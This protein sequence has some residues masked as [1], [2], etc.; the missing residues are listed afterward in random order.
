MNWIYIGAGIVL[1][2]IL[3]ALIARKQPGCTLM[4]LGGGIHMMAVASL[5][6][7]HGLTWGATCVLWAIALMLD[8]LLLMKG[9]K[10]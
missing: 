10:R 5:L 7:D 2:G 1:A 4:A 8:T 3:L 9:R 6:A